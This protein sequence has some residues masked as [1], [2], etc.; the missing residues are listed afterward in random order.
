M[1]RVSSWLAVLAT[2]AVTSCQPDNSKTWFQ[3]DF[4][5]A[6]AAADDRGTQVMIEFYADWCNWCRRLEAD[7]FSVPEVRRELQ[8]LVAMKLDAEKEGAD[9]AERFE[10]HGRPDLEDLGGR[11]ASTD[12]GIDDP[13]AVVDHVGA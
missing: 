12:E 10:E 3:G 1:K 6:L 4:E 13:L 5:A 8:A 11:D 2:L 9:L 7:T